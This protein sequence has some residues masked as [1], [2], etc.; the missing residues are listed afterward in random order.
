[1]TFD[2]SK[3]KGKIIE[4][5][6]SQYRFA[7]AMG[8]SER[9]TTLKMNNARCWKQPDICKASSLLG[10][11]YYEIPEYFFKEKVQSIE[12]KTA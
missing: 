10:I 5:F 6:G 11:E 9:T 7:E 2:Y 4:V 12:H 3:L 1:M 8:W